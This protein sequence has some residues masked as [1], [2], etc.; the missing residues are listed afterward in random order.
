MEFGYFTLSDNAYRNNTR[1]P[2]G[3][4]GEII[5]QAIHAEQIGLHLSLIHI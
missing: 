4:V 5:D 2:N 3:L 1:T